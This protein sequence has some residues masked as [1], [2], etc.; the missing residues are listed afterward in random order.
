MSCEWLVAKHRSLAMASMHKCASTS[1][2]AHEAF[3]D[4]RSAADVAEIETRVAWLRQPVLRL[5]SAWCG[6]HIRGPKNCL[7]FGLAEKDLATWERFVDFTFKH[8]NLHWDPQVPQLMHEGEYFPTITE[9][10]E[11]IATRIKA[12]IPGP[13]RWE[14]RSPAINV[15]LNYRRFDLEDKY[16]EDFELWE[17]LT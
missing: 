9:P 17:S 11:R 4:L 12:Y 2:R 1:L 16:A 3:I 14:N 10:F 7:M 5:H 15:N 6:F 13:L 8:G